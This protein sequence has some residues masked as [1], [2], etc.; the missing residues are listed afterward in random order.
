M[1]I[2]QRI[3]NKVHKSRNQAA[4]PFWVMDTWIWTIWCVWHQ[5]LRS[6]FLGGLRKVDV[7]TACC[8]LAGLEVSREGRTILSMWWS[9]PAMDWRLWAEG[10]AE[11]GKASWKGYMCWLKGFFLKHNGGQPQWVLTFKEM[12]CHRWFWVRL[13]LFWRCPG[14]GNKLVC[15][16]GEENPDLAG[17]IA[18]FLLPDLL[19]SGF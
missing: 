3:W 10:W 4:S 19:A 9:K 5:Y 14:K 13:V 15:Y 7:T 1:Q 11:G 2:C 17:S 6:I 18:K 12:L 16:P 8:D